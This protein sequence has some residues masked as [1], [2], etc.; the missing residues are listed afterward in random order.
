MSYSGVRVQAYFVT[1]FC[2]WMSGWLASSGPLAFWPSL[3]FRQLFVFVFEFF[4]RNCGV[5][6]EGQKQTLFFYFESLLM[7]N[8]LFVKKIFKTAEILH[9]AR[10]A[11]QHNHISLK[12]RGVCGH[13]SSRTDMETASYRLK[14]QRKIHHLARHLTPP[15]TRTDNTCLPENG[16]LPDPQLNPGPWFIF[17][18]SRKWKKTQSKYE[19]CPI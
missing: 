11:T 1:S 3:C 15:S 18:E 5:E 7:K 12:I 8:A 14:T 17:F 4:S 16:P 6:K 10:H 13:F 19:G 2:P 9:T